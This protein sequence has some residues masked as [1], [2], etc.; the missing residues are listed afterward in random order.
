MDEEKQKN[1]R[2]NFYITPT[3]VQRMQELMD[4]H[5]YANINQTAKYL[6][7]RGLEVASNLAG[8]IRTNDSLKEMVEIM[9]NEVAGLSSTATQSQIRDNTIEMSFDS[10]SS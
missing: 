6:F 7:M 3:Q 8:V 5:G 2:L 1:V 4:A 10:K 9:D